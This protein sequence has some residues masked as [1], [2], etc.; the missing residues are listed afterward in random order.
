M[1]EK[2]QQRPVAVREALEGYLGRSGLARRLA[3][4]QVIAEWP[5]L[6]GAQI[7]AVTSPDSVTPDGTLFV[8]VRTSAWMTELQLM[9]PEI[10]ARVNDSRRAQGRIKTI[11]WLLGS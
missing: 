3:H 10:L 7:A 2:K 6:V 5:G 4:A 1:T 8:R 9:T 11:R